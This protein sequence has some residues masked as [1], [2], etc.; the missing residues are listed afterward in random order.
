M[1]LLPPADGETVHYHYGPKDLVTISF[2][3]FITIILHAV[4]QEY[5]LDKISKRLHLSKVKHSKFN[6]SGQLVVFHLSSVIWCFYVVVTVS[7]PR[8]AD[9]WAWLPWCRGE[10]GS[11]GFDA[12]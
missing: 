7:G 12:I 8:D 6:E 5:I 10:R 9:G 4:V 3:I 1:A 11:N 2:Y